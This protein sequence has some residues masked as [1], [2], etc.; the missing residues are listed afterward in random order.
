MSATPDLTRRALVEV[1]AR[2]AAVPKH[3]VVRRYRLARVLLFTRPDPA[4]DRFAHLRRSY[5]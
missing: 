3:P 4:Q 2:H 5:D 1:A